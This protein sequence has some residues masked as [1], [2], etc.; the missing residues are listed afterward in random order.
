MY[1]FSRSFQ[2]AR[3]SQNFGSGT[4]II[5]SNLPFG[6]WG[7]VFGGNEALV[8]AKL[9]RLLHHAHIVQVRGESYRLREKRRSGLLRAHKPEQK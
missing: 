1:A 6:Q 4:G 2:G 9:D 7:D 5:T 8:S 3:R